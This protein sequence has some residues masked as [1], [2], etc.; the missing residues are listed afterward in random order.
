MAQTPQEKTLDVAP[1]IAPDSTLASVTD[2]IAGIVLR[3]K[4]SLGWIL[5]FAF[6]F[7]LMQLFLI[8]VSYLLFKGVGIWGLN[9]PIGWGF[10][11][12]NFVWWIGIGHAGTL[13]SAILLLL[14]Q[15]WR[16]AINRFAEAMT[17]FA[18]CCAGMFPILHMGRSWIAYWLFPYPNT[19]AIWP[20]FRSP[21]A[22]DVFAVSTYFTIS[23]VFWYIGMVPDFAT[24]R[25]QAKKHWQQV[26]YGSLALGWRGSAFHWAR[27]EKASLLLAGLSTPLVLSVHSVISFDFAI[28]ILPG[29][30]TTIFPPYFVAG[31]VYDGFAMVLTLMIPVRRF[32]GLEGLMTLRHINNMAKVM[33]TTGL[34][35]AY[36]YAMEAF[37]ALVYSGDHFE[38]FMMQNRMFGNYGW[39]YWLLVLTNIAI[40][41]LLWFYKIRTNLVWLW[42]ISMVINV[43]MWMERFV[44]VITSL[45]RDFV[46][47]SWGTYWPT[48]WDW[49]VFLGTIGLFMTLIFLFVRVLPMITMFELRMIT[50]KKPIAPVKE[51]VR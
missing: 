27:Y 19:M 22:W 4:T 24:L 8:A 30:H 37:F 2:K 16:N 35:V 12:V 5:G 40:P 3:R 6:F 31:A 51:P 14:N 25:D 15:S 33:L 45:T 11:I 20:Q 32:Y 29:W 44:I 48:I 42:C 10:A 28:S 1:V 36:G 13:I 18:V 43:G 17:I 41:Q 7:L 26:V 9:I 49:A 21:L 34:I 46:P 39:A 38:K 23:L 50:P 47:S